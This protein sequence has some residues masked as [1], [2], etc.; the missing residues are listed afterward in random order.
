MTNVFLVKFL[1]SFFCWT[2]DAALTFQVL[3]ENFIHGST[4]LEPLIKSYV[5]S[6][7]TIQRVDNPSGTLLS[8]GLGEPKFHPNQTAF[9]E[10]WGRPQ[11]DGPALRASGLIDFGFSIWSTQPAYVSNVLWPIIQNDLSYVANYWNMTGFDLWEEI[12]GSSFFTIAVQH[13][14]LRKGFEFSSLFGLTNTTYYKNSGMLLCFLQSFWN[15]NYIISNLNNGRSGLDVSTILASIHTFSADLGCDEETY[16]PCSS[17]AL[18]NHKSVVDSFRNIYHINSGFSLNA[19]IAIGRYP[20][21]EYYD[22][23][24]WYLTT[25]AAA[26]QLYS[27]INVWKTVNHINVTETSFNFFQ[28]LLPNISI[29]SYNSGSM[30]F[31]NLLLNVKSYADGFVNV[32]RDYIPPI[33][34]MHEQFSKIDG[35]S[36]SAGALTWSDISL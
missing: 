24:P 22:G 18:A 19:A 10:P 13:K 27:A 15:K 8:E 33:G 26:E 25:L 30:V 28:A 29:G 11:R 21:D 31:E 5:V 3:I 4:W 35:M 32:V 36:V 2:R 23:N 16:Q 20:E 17:R 34:P 14:A 1:I 12:N 9:L 6:V 7:G